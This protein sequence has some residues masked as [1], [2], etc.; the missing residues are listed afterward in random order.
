MWLWHKVALM[1]ANRVLDDH[2][3]ALTKAEIAEMSRCR[4]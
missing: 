4:Q 2:E 3:A 1:Q